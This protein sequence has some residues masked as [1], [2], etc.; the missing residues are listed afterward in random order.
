MHRRHNRDSLFTRGEA[1]KF[2]MT[3][4]ALVIF[5]LVLNLIFWLGLIFGG[6]WALNHFG[7]I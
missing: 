6:L 4:L 3:G 5:S 7:V 1:M 2:G